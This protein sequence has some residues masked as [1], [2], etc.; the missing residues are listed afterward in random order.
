M[1][2]AS[3]IPP[4][5]DGVSAIGE[6][7]R[8]RARVASRYPW[9]TPSCSDARRSTTRA[10]N[11]H[12]DSSGWSGQVCASATDSPD[13]RAPDPAAC[14]S[15][16]HA[17]AARGSSSS[18]VAPA[19]GASSR[20]C[21]PDASARGSSPRVA[22]DFVGSGGRGASGTG[23]SSPGLAASGHRRREP[24][25]PL[26]VQL[27]PPLSQGTIAAFFATPFTPLENSTW[28][29]RACSSPTPI[30]AAFA[31]SMSPCA[32]PAS[33]SPPP[34]TA[35]RRCAACSAPRPICCSPIW[36]CPAPTGSRSARRRAPTPSSRACR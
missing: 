7:R 12:K 22:A 14:G 27:T 24:G 15:S 32:R 26:F 18:G 28:P 17:A 9:A 8:G 25:P 31:S 19:C 23:P 36:G 16:P 20:G 29:S 33:R 30:R 6:A 5:I 1:R 34:P 11:S 35:P 2:A 3:S 4:G 13:G 21:A 10:A